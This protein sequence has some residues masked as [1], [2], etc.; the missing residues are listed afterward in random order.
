MPGYYYYYFD[1][2]YILLM[3]V[4]LL[5]IAAQV[6][7]KATFSRYRRVESLSGLTGAEA[8]RKMLDQARLFHVNVMMIGGELSDHYDPSTRTVCLSKDVHD[9]RSV[10]SISVACHECGHAI[11]HSENYAPLAFR[12]MFFPSANLGSSFGIP[13]FIA[14]MIFNLGFLSTVG[15]VFFAAAVIFQVITLPV[16]FNASRR[17]LIQMNQYG[18]IADTEQSSARRVL[19]AAAMTYVAATAVA[20]LN[21]LRLILISRRRD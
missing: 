15:I 7:V 2:S 21:L 18:L 12:T 1:W 8:A 14:G 13:L 4:G 5:A 11:Q 16:E 6:N 20:V 9:G 10:A 3:V 19:G 17:A